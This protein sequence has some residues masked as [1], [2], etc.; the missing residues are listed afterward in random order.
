[1]HT[2]LI[3]HVK[4][5]RSLISPFPNFLRNAD[6]S[7]AP[8]RRSPVHRLA[9]TRR[10]LCRNISAAGSTE[11]RLERDKSAAIRSYDERRRPL[12]SLV[13]LD[14]RVPIAVILCF[15][16]PNFAPGI[17]FSPCD[18]PSRRRRSVISIRRTWRERSSA[19]MLSHRSFPS[20]ATLTS[21]SVPCAASITV[22]LENRY[23]LDLTITYCDHSTSLVFVKTKFQDVMYF[24]VYDR[25]EW[26]TM[27]DG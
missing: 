1:M 2:K 15:T 8:L 3:L 13:S 24:D 23:R 25:D 10:M 12:S 16:S 21:I 11:A 5:D 26:C 4:E 7:Y 6:R 17:A 19:R 18:I 20:V 22:P 9:T 27:R 14:I